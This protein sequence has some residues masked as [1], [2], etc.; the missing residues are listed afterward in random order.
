MFYSQKLDNDLSFDNVNMFATYCFKF[1]HYFCVL[2][3]SHVIVLGDVNTSHRPI[4]HCDPTDIVSRRL[5]FCFHSLC[6]FIFVLCI[7]LRVGLEFE[8]HESCI[9]TVNVELLN[10]LV[11]PQRQVFVKS[12]LTDE[13]IYSI[14]PNG[15]AHTSCHLS[16]ES[17]V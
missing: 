10:C 11:Q 16:I 13:C 9:D 14:R 3:S 6:L 2:F 7:L 12:Y 15:Q 1:T 5:K 4:D 17:L 8:R